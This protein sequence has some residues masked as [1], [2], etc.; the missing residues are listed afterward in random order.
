LTATLLLTMSLT[1]LEARTGFASTAHGGRYSVRD[2]LRLAA[3]TA[4]V[5]VV[6]DSNG[7]P[8][9]LGE[10]QRLATEA[11]RHALL[12]MDIG[13][14]FENCTVPG[15]WCQSAHGDPYRNSKRTTIDDL[16]LLCGYHHRICDTEDWEITR[17]HGRAWLT[18]PKSYDPR[19]VPRINEY[20]RPLQE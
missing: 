3:E 14:V 12:L 6:M 16:A 9:H 13:C 19:Q 7:R 8:L 2:L 18:P 10:T 4:V 20:F 17:R 5:P 11:Q 15:V 1:D